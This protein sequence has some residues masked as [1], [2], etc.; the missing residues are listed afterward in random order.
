ML[1]RAV[2]LSGG[3]ADRSP[4]GNIA[5]PRPSMAQA[6]QIACDSSLPQQD[7]LALTWAKYVD[8]GF[9]VKLIKKRAG[10]ELWI[11][12]S[13]ETRDMLERMD[14]TS[15]YII[16]NEETQRP[17][18]DKNEF[19]R[20]FR[21]VRQRAGITRNITFQD[22]RTTALTALGNNGATNAEIVSFSGHKVSSPTI[23]VYVKPDREAALRARKKLDGKDK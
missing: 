23:D 4:Q 18:K 16:V 12:L 7:I 19:G 3:T 8:G 9:R 17:Y 2:P 21:K 22:M 6:I 10:K 1:R 5:P 11:P 20:V 14:R 13:Q 15:T